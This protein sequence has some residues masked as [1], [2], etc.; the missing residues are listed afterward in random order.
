MTVS[1]HYSTPP[2]LGKVQLYNNILCCNV[3]EE[4]TT[5]D[6]LL[7]QREGNSEV[8]SIASEGDTWRRRL[9]IL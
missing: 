6:L 7:I 3:R 8:I 2:Y 1:S 9:Q 5:F 4:D